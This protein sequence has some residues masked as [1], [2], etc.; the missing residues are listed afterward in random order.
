MSAKIRNEAAPDVDTIATVIARAFLDAGHSSRTE[1]FIVNALRDSGN[2]SVSLVA[3]VDGNLVGHV[4][5][6]PVAISD[7]TP[8]W[9]GLAPVSVLPDYQKQGIGGQLV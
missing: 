9:Y 2:L 8:G 3:E 5:A 7:K 1:Q 6:S 4:G